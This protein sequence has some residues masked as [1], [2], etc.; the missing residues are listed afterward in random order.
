MTSSTKPV[1]DTHPGLLERTGVEYPIGHIGRPE[2]VAHMILY[3]ASDDASF[4]TGGVFIVDGGV[5]AGR[6]LELTDLAGE[7]GDKG[8]G[9]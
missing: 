1:F 9:G 3:L 4:T 8:I 5:T 6:K 2:D 7:I